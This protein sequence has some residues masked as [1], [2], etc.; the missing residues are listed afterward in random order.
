MHQVDTS[1]SSVPAPMVIECDGP[2]GIAGQ[3]VT[4]YLPDVDGS[5]QRELQLQEVEV[6]GFLLRPPSP[7]SPPLPP[8][9]P[10]L[11]PL[12]T[13]Q[14][15]QHYVFPGTDTLQAAA[16]AAAE[17]DELI[18][19]DGTYTATAGQ[20]SILRFPRCLRSIRAL[21]VG[22]AILDGQNIIGP[23]VVMAGSNTGGNLC[24]DWN[25]AF[26]KIVLTGLRITRSA[27][28][29][30]VMSS[31]TSCW[32]EVRNCIIHDNLG[33]GVDFAVSS[34]GPLISV[35]TSGGIEEWVAEDKHHFCIR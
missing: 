22:N 30:I 10:P 32:L 7:P 19:L 31:H 16:D 15:G 12:P 24:G 8:P 28:Q 35:I 20:R 21:N 34:R 11:A 17:G 26:Q 13:L 5:T 1:T 2:V 6:R 3:Y 9:S 33:G 14:A 18:L 25:S 4:I 29:G 23:V 27:A